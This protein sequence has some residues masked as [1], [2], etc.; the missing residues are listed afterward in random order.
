MWT[1]VEHDRTGHNQL[2]QS[3]LLGQLTGQLRFVLLETVDAALREII[4]ATTAKPA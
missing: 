3:Q 1:F 2:A 4:E